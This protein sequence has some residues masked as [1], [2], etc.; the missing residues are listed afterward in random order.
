LVLGYEVHDWP[1][2]LRQLV[3]T[4]F[5]RKALPSWLPQDL[6]VA[7]HFA[8]RGWRE[9]RD[10]APGQHT[11][12]LVQHYAHAAGL[13]LNPFVAQQEHSEGRYTPLQPPPPT[14]PAQS[15]SD[16]LLGEFDATYYSASYPDVVAAGMDPL[17]HFRHTGWRE[18]RNPRASVF[19]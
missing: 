6:D 2:R 8:F 16:L 12:Q 4:S 9:G 14:L 18:G 7:A 17:E 19:L 10:P 3:D 1:G 11:A 13:L 5:Y 15:Q